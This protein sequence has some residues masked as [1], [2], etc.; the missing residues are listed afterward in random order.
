MSEKQVR[1]PKQLKTRCYY[2]DY[3]NHMIRFYL[4]TPDTLMVAGKRKADVANW[5]AVQAVFHALKDENRQALTE[6]YRTSHR[7]TEGVR[8]YCDRT[9]T[10]EPKV[11]I[12]I[13]K[14]SSA[15]AKR[16]GLI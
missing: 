7:L 13:T 3:V 14:V 1:K 15:I 5:M 4:T 6:I 9:G 12:M 11:W 2:S 8:A 16:R 10:D